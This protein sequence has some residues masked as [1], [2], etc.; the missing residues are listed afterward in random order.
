MIK[1]ALLVFIFVMLLTS[2][3][4]ADYTISSLN[5]V[6]SYANNDVVSYKIEIAGSGDEI[7]LT[8]NSTKHSGDTITFNAI[9]DGS[10]YVAYF[11]IDFTSSSSSTQQG[12]PK[13]VVNDF[14]SVVVKDSGEE[15]EDILIVDKIKPVIGTFDL[16]ALGDNFENYYKGNVNASLSG[17]SDANTYLKRFIAYVV[18]IASLNNF[19]TQYTKRIITDNNSTTINLDLP[20]DVSDGNYYVVIDAE[21]IAGNIGSEANVINTKKILTVDNTP[22]EITNFNLG[23]LEDEGKYYVGSSTFTIEILFEDSGVGINENTPNTQIT[24]NDP[25][26]TIINT[27]RDY[28]STFGGFYV[29]IDQDFNSGTYVVNI[30]IE[31]LLE[32]KNDINFTI[33]IDTISPTKPSI[34]NLTIDADKDV[35][36]TWTAATDALSGISHYEIYRSTSSFTTITTQTKVTET[37]NLTYTDTSSKSSNTRYYYGVVAVDNAGNKSLPDVDNIHT[38]PDISIVIEDGNTYTNKTTP[39][40]KATFS[41]DVNSL[42]FSCNGTTWASKIEVSGTTHTVTT[43]NMTSGNGCNTTEEQKTI[44]VKAF[45]ETDYPDRTAVSTRKITYDKTKP[46]KPT[47]LELTENNDGT[48]RLDWT[49]STDELSGI[50]EYRIYYAVDTETVTTSSSFFTSSNIYYV[51]SPNQTHFVSFKVSAIDRA[52]NESDLTEVVSGETKRYGPTFNLSISPSNKID[53]VYYVGGKELTFTITSNQDLTMTPVVSVRVLPESFQTKTVTG[54]NRNYSLK[55]TFIS[56]GD[57]EIRVSG[58]NTQNETAQTIYTLKVK[59]AEPSFDFNYSVS[60][61]GLFNFEVNNV[62]EDVYRLQYVLLTKGQICVK[63]IDYFEDI[64]EGVFNCEFDSTTF[65]DG[66]YNLEV[67]AY[68]VYNNN[69]TK[70][71][72]I[73]IAN[74][75]EDKQISD[76]LRTALEEISIIEDNIKLLQQLLVEIDQAVLEKLNDLKYEKESGDQKYNENDFILARDHYSQANILL[77]EI[78]EIL[79]EIKD[80]K[81]IKQS[82]QFNENHLPLI[83]RFTN[84]VNVTQQTEALYNSKAISFEREFKV[85]EINTKKY[86]LVSLSFINNSSEEKTITIVEDIPNSFAN[87]IKYVVFNRE[88]EVLSSN[89]L[90]KDTLT[91]LPNSFKTITYSLINPITEVD[92]VTKFPLIETAFTDPIVLSGEVIKEKIV[93]DVPINYML[94]VY[95]FIVAI[96]IILMMVGVDLIIKSNK[97]KNES[98]VKPSTKQVMNDY[99]SKAQEKK[100]TESNSQNK[101]QEKEKKKFDDDYSFIMGAI[102]KRE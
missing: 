90:I 92:V 88:I 44:Y 86:F 26:S 55:H 29:P 58:T 19:K 45:S 40:I 36:I 76:E 95:I 84:D 8:I 37:S 39:E 53:D 12:W 61:E 6:E 66:V 21:D 1:K 31:D 89:P 65:D 42:Q 68:D 78:K 52:G 54:A 23:D 11:Y 16:V 7:P 96:A 38:G 98:L 35:I 101:N 18:P 10:D 97:K 71:I 83:P 63:E 24:I 20:T 100:P 80:V 60:D 15:K 30:V 82:K 27:N 77:N 49:R 48:I 9:P 93:Y 2:F 67:I 102:K 41:S 72:E 59:T 47:N 75:D 70:T 17:Y 25:N 22:P 69:K 74:I 62:S 4:Y 50:D 28:N 33:D 32:N 91:I 43:F 81:S 79:P 13:I 73:E 51:Y 5:I 46:T 94:L 34:S 3:I 85:I 99:F 57:A 64:E 56:D 87:N 14:D